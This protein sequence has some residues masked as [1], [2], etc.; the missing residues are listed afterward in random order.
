[1]IKFYLNHFRYDV[2]LT[3]CKE[4]GKYASYVVYYL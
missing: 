4:N 2:Y 3:K 1:M